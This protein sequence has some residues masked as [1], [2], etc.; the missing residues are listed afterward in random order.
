[1]GR[2]D[3]EQALE[4]REAA[5]PVLRALAGSDAVAQ[6]E[7][8]DLLGTVTVRVLARLRPGHDIE[9][10]AAYAKQTARNV[11]K[12]WLRSKRHHGRHIHRDANRD[13]S[14][15]P[16]TEHLYNRASLTPSSLA[17]LH[18]DQRRHAPMIEAALASLTATERAVL[19]L[20]FGD[21]RSSAE[22]AEILGYR[23]AAVVDTMVARARRKLR[24][25]LPQSLMG[26][27][28]GM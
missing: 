3:T 6:A 16:L 8:P 15:T 12:D 10:V 1:M 9:N 18:D 2:H 20:R 27:I 19:G 14:S 23:S 26:P 22:A 13:S 24:D 11:F 21:G 4:V 28:L 25:R 7:V 17:A 5:E